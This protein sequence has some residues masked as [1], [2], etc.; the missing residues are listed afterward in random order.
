M[1]LSLTNIFFLST[2]AFEH[3]YHRI[4]ALIDGYQLSRVSILQ[5]TAHVAYTPLYIVEF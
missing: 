2:I 3:V 5:W 1:Q 4:F